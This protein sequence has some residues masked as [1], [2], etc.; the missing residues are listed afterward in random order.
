MMQHA[1]ID[2]F[3]KHYFSRRV[4][5]DAQAIVR[6]F[7]PQNELMRAACRMSRWIDPDRPWKLTSEQSAS[8]NY[9]PHVLK[10]ER[11][12]H[13]HRARASQI[14]KHEELG[15][16]IRNVKQRLRDALRIKI[17][18]EWDQEQ[19]VK[20]IEQQLSGL[21]FSKN[22]KVKLESASNRTPEHTRLIEC[23]VSLP[24][25]TIKEEMQRRSDAINAVIAYC[26]I[27][28]GNTCSVRHQ[29]LSIKFSQSLQS[30]RVMNPFDER[31]KA[32]IVA[33]YEEKRPRICFLCIGNEKKPVEERIHAFSTPGD[34]SKHFKRQHL[35]YIEENDTIT[36]PICKVL[37]D[38]RSHLQDHALSVHGTVS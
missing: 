4:T 34:L 11:A 20:N 5:M 25:S 9:D 23:I 22:V 18:K 17:K 10:L 35:R 3:L 19:A 37:L 1:K 32:A 33:A 14:Q 30:S 13:K 16:E 8:V 2:T 15:R 27:E 6:G 36:C 29:A 12:R 38:S 21:K 7:A 31:L 28:E 26:K 24:G